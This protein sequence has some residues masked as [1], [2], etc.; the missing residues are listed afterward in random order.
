M[1]KCST[2]FPINPLVKFDNNC[3]EQTVF[4]F[5]KQPSIPKQHTVPCMLVS[6]GV[7]DTNY[8]FTEIFWSKYIRFFFF[9]WGFQD[10]SLILSYNK[11]NL[12]GR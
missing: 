2:Y 7:D 6:S 3:E 4:L 8:Q 11:E 10:G 12:L 1:L 5:N 9:F